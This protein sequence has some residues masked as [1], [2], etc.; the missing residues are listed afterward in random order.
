MIAPALIAVCIR[1]S[2]AFLG[3]NINGMLA[4]GNVSGVVAAPGPTP[5][6]RARTTSATTFTPALSSDVAGLPFLGN[7][8]VGANYIP[9]AT[10]VADVTSTYAVVLRRQSNCSLDEDFFLPAAPTLSES[11]ATSLTGAQDYFH[12]LAGLT[13]TPD[14]FARGCANQVLGLPAT[15]SIL[16]L[17]VTSAGAAISAVLGN[18]GLEIVLTNLTANTH[19]TTLLPN[20]SLVATFS[21]A[22]LRNN[23]SFDLVVPGLTDPTTQ[24]PA[25][26]VYLGNGD[27]TFQTPMYYDVPN[28]AGNSVTI[29]DVNGDGYPDIVVLSIQSV[30]NNNGLVTIGGAVT[31]LLGN[32]KGTFTTGP[33]STLTWNGGYQAETGDFNNDGK[34]DLL[35]GGTVLLGSGNGAFTQGPTNAALA[36]VNNSGTGTTSVGDLRNSGNLDAVVTGPGSVN[37]F[38]GNGDG[39][40]KTGPSYAGLPDDMQTTITDI[41]GD[42]NLDIVMGSSTGGIYTSGGQDMPIPMYQILMGRGDGTFVDS[43]VYNTGVYSSSYGTHQIA[44]AD[45]NGDGLTDVL[46]LNNSLESGFYVTNS[47]AMLPGGGKGDLGTAIASPINA[48]NPSMVVA[49]DMNGDGK[50]DAV[51]AGGSTVSVL[52]NQGNGSFAGEQDY[53]LPASPVSLAV[54]DFNGDGRMDVAVGV[55]EGSAPSGVFVLFG[56]ANGTLGTPV[57][58]DSSLFPSGLAAGSLTGDGRTDLV[59]A[60]QGNANT[61]GSSNGALHV[62]LGQANGTFTAAAPPKTT[63]TRYTVD[64]LGSLTRDGKL[65]LIVAGYV[66]GT[67]GN[68][69]TPNVYTLTGNGDGTFQAPVTVALA[70]TDGVGATSISLADFNGDGNLDVAVGNPADY[71][72]VLL[73]NGDGTLVDTALA[74][75]QRPG[76]VGA[77][78]L[79]TGGLPELLVGQSVGAQVGSGGLAVFLNTNPWVDKEII[80]PAPTI[81]LVANAE[82]GVTTI[83]PNTWVEIKGSNLG[84]AGDTRTWMS[85]DFAGSQMP[86]NLDGVSVTVNG[87]P[88]Y[89]YYISPTQVNI[90]V[91]PNAISGSVPVQVSNNG[92]ISASFMVQARADSPSFFV[93]GGGPYIAATHANG[94]Y[95]GPTSLYPGLT[96]PAQPGETIVM[97]ANGF[98][99]TSSTVVSGSET[100]SGTLSPLPAITIGGVPAKV[101]FAGL[102]V[103][104]GEFQFN[105]IVPSSLGNGDQA[106]IATYNGMTT[107]AGTLITVQQ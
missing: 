70:G 39:T 92:A 94:S 72:E 65:D 21:A 54:G 91:P 60:D 103:T 4:N 104:P 79:V 8:L 27:G 32:G 40:F 22:S 25:T 5:R 59:V 64:A 6:L 51:V 13:T 14:V 34:K 100:Q 74:L 33:V 85:S 88:S 53:S 29:D 20:T 68:P 78:N 52:T 47:L 15:S 62:Y 66:A 102:N 99:S 10:T 75:G 80:A 28:P 63:A 98:G 35:A 2:K 86:T 12:Q 37:I 9:N 107:Q 31:T 45:F 73:G 89:I 50:P 42:G 17:G 3:N 76:A 83:A 96:T 67:S 61:G 41:D 81:T 23:G 55:G 26:A 38:Y 30:K 71:T 105:V 82:G 44:S 11:Y 1:L 95:I 24:Q 58:I 97:Y 18:Y 84:P 16:L 19:T 46:V 56:Q 48:A 43:P 106:T 87:V 90:L 101:T 69:G 7:W 93:F 57:Q 36:A 49:A 77:A